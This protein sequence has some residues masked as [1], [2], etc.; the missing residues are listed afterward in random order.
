L[1]FFMNNRL[2][3]LDLLLPILIESNNQCQLIEQIALVFG[4]GIIVLRLCN[5]KQTLC[6][7]VL[8]GLLLACSAFLTLTRMDLYSGEIGAWATMHGNDKILCSKPRLVVSMWRRVRCFLS[9]VR[10]G[11]SK[12]LIAV[13]N[14]W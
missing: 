4:S 1:L 3:L 9:H 14:L 12:L 10:C 6:R 2:V 5:D 8:S 11:K 13:L 7:W